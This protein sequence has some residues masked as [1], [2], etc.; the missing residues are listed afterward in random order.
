M[1]RVAGCA[2]RLAAVVLG[3]AETFGAVIG[4]F[5][6]TRGLGKYFTRIAASDIWGMP[7]LTLTAL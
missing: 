7:N 6:V 5:G 3:V 1:A 2:A 4:A